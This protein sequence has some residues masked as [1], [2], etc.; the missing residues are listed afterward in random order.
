MAQ[1]DVTSGHTNLMKDTELIGFT[2]LDDAK[3]WVFQDGDLLAF[4]VILDNA[5]R[6]DSFY[7]FVELLCFARGQT[8]PM[9]H[10]SCLAS[11]VD[12]STRVVQIG[13]ESRN[14]AWRGR[15]EGELEPGGESLSMIPCRGWWTRARSCCG[16]SCRPFWFRSL[17]KK[18]FKPNE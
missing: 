7:R 9:T 13:E 15:G 5:R 4:S 17:P 3:C 14:S 16:Q 2:S 1:R 6:V 18:C 10:G 12:S 11:P 8:S